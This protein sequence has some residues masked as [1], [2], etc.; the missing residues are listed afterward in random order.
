MQLVQHTEQPDGLLITTNT[1]R[2]KLVAWTSSIIQVRYTLDAEFSRIE[3]LMVVPQPAG[4]VGYKVTETGDCLAFSTGEVTVRINK[5][6]AAFTYLDKVGRVLTREPDRG[7]KTLVPVDVVKSVFDDSVAIQL[8]QGVDGVRSRAENVKQVVDR[9]AYQTKLEFEWADDEAL[10]GLGSHEEGV[11]NLRGTHQF[12]YQSNMK[13]VVP[14]L[15]STRGYGIMWDSY[16]LMTFH[17]DAFGSYVWTDVAAELNFYFIYG[18]DLD[19]IVGGVRKLTGQAPMFPK[20]AFGY[21]QSKETYYNQAEIIAIVKEYRDRNLPLDGIVQDWKSWPEGLWGQKSLDPARFPDPAGMMEEIHGLNAHLMIS[22]WPIMN[23]GG[24]NSNEMREQD[25]LLGNRANYDAF[26]PKARALYWKQANEGLFSHGIDAWWCD[27]TEPFEADWKGAVKPEPEERLRINTEEGKRYLDPAYINAYSLL[28]SHGI[29]EGQRQVTDQ[30][31]VVNLTRS[32][33]T[34]QHRYGTITWSGDTAATWQTLRDQ[35]PAGL[36]F[37]VTGS[38]Y[39]TLDIGAFFVRN[40][41]D[42]WFWS[43]DY[44][45]GVADL[46]Y[47]ELYTRWFQLGAFLPMFRSHGTD[48]P[49]EIWRF[50]EPGE[51]VYDSLAKFLQLRYRLLPYI[52]SL[53]GHVTQENYTMLRALVF[54]FRNDPATYAIRNQFMFGP[55]IL[56]NPVTEPMYYGP[57]SVPLEGIRK[58]R[59]VYLPAGSDWYDYWTGEHLVGGQTVEAEAGLDKLPLYVRSGSIVPTGPDIQYAGEQPDA[60]LELTIYAGQ[61]GSFKLYEDEGDNY[62]YESGAFSTILIHWK[63]ETRTLTLDER[64][65]SYPGMP[66][67]RQFKINLISGI[68]PAYSTGRTAQQPPVQYEGKRVVVVL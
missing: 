46:G 29:F 5:K 9:R 32:A 20:W 4:P 67:R 44:D 56:V 38:P 1:G 14:V 52:Y 3:S 22:V 64:H 34:G 7:G 19:Q 39:W 26:K 23:P 24:A 47:R 55:A 25:C 30:K 13:A 60:P 66:D 31:R 6:T 18:P 68:D 36:N 63:E 27:C 11:M 42:L 40:K 37:C 41:P 45:E 15:V 17:D 59:P 21:I 33:Y 16:S 58:T 2:I 51:P 12:L 8:G 54:D 65:G 62:S 10:Y 61:D 48:T 28:H 57:G 49:R 53:A 35:I 50:G 43:G